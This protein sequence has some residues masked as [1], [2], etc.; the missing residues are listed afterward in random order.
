MRAIVLSGGGAKG[1]YQVGVWKALKKLKIDFGIVTGTSIGA[2]NG[3]MMVQKDYFKVFWLW[4]NIS[5]NT[6]YKED[7]PNTKEPEMKEIYKSYIKYF[8]KSGGI[9]LDKM[10]TLL[11]KTYNSRK[12]RNS[13]INYGIVTFNLSKKQPL[14]LQKKDIKEDFLDYVLASACCYP[15]FQKKEI[16]GEQYIDGGYYDNL[17]I[18]LAIEIGADEVIAVDL[19][20]IG[21]KKKVKDKSVKITYIR[22]RNDIGSFLVFN[23][24]MASRAIKYGYYDTMK[25]FKQLDGDK[26]TFKKNQLKEN[27]LK[28]VDKIS[29]YYDNLILKAHQI[30]PG[31]I[32]ITTLEHFIKNKEL[33]KKQESLNEVIEYI[34]QTFKL[35]TCYN[36]NIKKLNKIIVEK[37]N[38]NEPI[39]KKF[40]EDK[41]KN[42]KIEELLNSSSVIKYIYNLLE[43]DKNISEVLTLSFI[44]PKEFRSAVYIKVIK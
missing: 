25:T 35:D 21:L 36:Y 28:Y 13:P 27:Y 33:Y 32:A 41:L 5:F 31:I 14:F 4:Q 7:F 20:A 11:S 19:E 37:N 3:L 26:Y 44:F 16:N 34:S 38:K 12:F 1:A 8:I 17:P 22:P 2:I 15:A 18:N 10:E 30:K 39:S 24:K 43:D 40:I 42:K 9:N 6:I 29:N 23:K